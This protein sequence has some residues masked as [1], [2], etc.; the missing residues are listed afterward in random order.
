[1]KDIISWFYEM[2]QLKR[3]KRSGWWVAGV[4]DPESVAEHS[5]RAALIGYVLAGLEGADR[6]KTA[7]MCL[8][9]DVHEARINDLHK[10]GH[11]YIKFKE[12]EKKAFDEQTG[13]LPEKIREEIRTL[14]GEYHNDGSK[15]GIIARDAD[16]FECAVQAKEYLELGYKETQN[17]I[18]NVENL[19][20]TNSAKK[21]FE[22][23]KNTDS[24]IWWKNL[25]KTE[26]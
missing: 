11:R 2:G 16:L 5:F 26:R 17:W 20:K 8:F 19:L 15:E 7:V 21:L 10:V 12:A 9:N 24:N 3:V 23:M 6:N 14:F 1:M 22:E 4:K 13:K 25:K 18:D